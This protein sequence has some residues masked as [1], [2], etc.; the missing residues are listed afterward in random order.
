MKT[1]WVNDVLDEATKTVRS[2]PRWMLRPE[3]RGSE[4]RPAESRSTERVAEPTGE[5]TEET[6]NQD[7]SKR[8][9]RG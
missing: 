7:K 6:G 3:V 1:N 4:T 2:W 9:R 8:S 5:G